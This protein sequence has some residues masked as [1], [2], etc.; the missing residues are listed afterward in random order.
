MIF[1]MGLNL[2]LA[3]RREDVATRRERGE[4]ATPIRR[5]RGAVR[6]SMQPE[7]QTATRNRAS[8][9][10]RR[11]R[12]GSSRRIVCHY[13]TGGTSAPLETGRVRGRQGVGRVS[14]TPMRELLT[15][16]PSPAPRLPDPMR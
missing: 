16:V 15:E 9:I 12:E 3:R 4:F 14:M 6:N 5:G 11:G 1:D 13:G 8:P 2:R 10:R 7:C